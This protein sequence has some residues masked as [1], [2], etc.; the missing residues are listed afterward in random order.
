QRIQ[1]EIPAG[2]NPFTHY[3]RVIISVDTLKNIGQYRH[4]LERI[5]WDAVVIDESHNLINAGSQRRAL[6][7]IL[8]PEGATV[9]AS[10]RLAIITEGAAGAASPAA[11]QPEAAAA[12]V[13]SPGAGPETPQERKDVED[14]PSAKKAMAEAG[15]ARD[16]V[17]GTGRDGRVMKE[18]VAR[19]A[20][21]PAAASSA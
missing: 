4:H 2:R 10:A 19:A 12:A 14:A 8:A 15:I 16:A 20:S 9:E 1:R 18:D 13:Q 11:A 21:A 6:A 7:E 17:T 3:K 5:R